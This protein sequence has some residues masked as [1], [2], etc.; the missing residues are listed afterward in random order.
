MRKQ[1]HSASEKAIARRLW[2]Y[3]GAVA[4]IP[5]LRSVVRSL[6][7]HWLGAQQARL[8]VQRID[9]RPGRPGRK[10]LIL[11]AEAGREAARAEGRLEEALDELLALNISCLDPARGLALIPFRQG[12]E[13]AWYVFDL[14]SPRGLDAWRYHAD[15]LPTRRSLSEPLDTALVDHVF[16]GS[17]DFGNAA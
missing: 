17:L 5:Y 6:R 14:F 13:L 8:Q 2:T 7:E 11:R 16:S 10:V 3:A 1:L 12:D 15:P 9:A 4:A